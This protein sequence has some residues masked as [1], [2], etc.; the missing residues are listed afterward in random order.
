MHK[1]LLILMMASSFSFAEKAKRKDILNIDLLKAIE[2]TKESFKYVRNSYK[3]DSLELRTKLIDNSFF[4]T[5]YLTM[6]FKKQLNS[7]PYETDINIQKC[8]KLILKK[9]SKVGLKKDFLTK[10]E[11]ES[12]A[13]IS[14]QLIVENKMIKLNPEQSK[15]KKDQYLPTFSK[16][17]KNINYFVYKREQNEIEPFNNEVIDTVNK[18]YVRKIKKIGKITEFEYLFANY[19]RLQI[20]EMA[21]L[22]DQTINMMSSKSGEVVLQHEDYSQIFAEIDEKENK[23]NE[24]IDR[25]RNSS[26]LRMKDYY[27][28]QISKLSKEILAL[29]KEVSLFDLQEQIQNAKEKKLSIYNLLVEADSDTDRDTLYTQLQDID[30]KI[31]DLNDEILSKATR[32][33]LTHGDIYKFT[34][35][36]LKVELNERRKNKERFSKLYGTYASFGDLIMAGYV[37]GIVDGQIIKAIV[38]L[39]EVHENYKTPFQQAL[40][41][42]GKVARMFLIINP[43]TSPYATL[44]FV[45]FD[46]LKNKKIVE[47]ERA[48]DAHLI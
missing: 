25:S 14:R 39:P 40:K 8:Y 20:M 18:Y 44:A 6:Q 27:D 42:G 22:L 11:S 28:R 7:C 46:A 9:I 23:L 43:I 5:R 47:R 29:R 33:K 3:N 16:Y 48:N 24:F 38:E 32:V 35:N 41:I 12:I 37:S 45:I 30:L 2:I 36:W 10:I 26:D 34:M 15:K 13:L 4:L 17:L 21:N 19:N 31:K 1:L